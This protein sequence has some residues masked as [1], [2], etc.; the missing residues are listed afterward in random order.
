VFP[1][2]VSTFLSPLSEGVIGTKFSVDIIFNTKNK[3]NE[4]TTMTTTY[5][6]SVHKSPFIDE[7]FFAA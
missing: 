4:I 6:R 5:L 1:A 2:G 3:M 7:E